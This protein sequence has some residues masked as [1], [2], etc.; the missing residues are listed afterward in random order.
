[1]PKEY[2]S[3]MIE[4]ASAARAAFGALDLDQLARLVD[5]L[6]VLLWSTDEQLRVTSRR[7]GGLDLLGPVPT[8]QEGLRVGDGSVEAP[9]ESARAVAAHRAALLGT[10]TAY[11]VTIRGRTFSARV[12]PLRESVAGGGDGR[13]VGVMGMAFDITARRRAEDALRESEARLRTIIESEP[14]CVKLLDARPQ[15]G[16]AFPQ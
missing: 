4:V 1:M 15:A 6:P 8:P 5:Q 11:E 2:A 3:A 14:E 10:P 16:F 7:G 12:E 9:A 13:I